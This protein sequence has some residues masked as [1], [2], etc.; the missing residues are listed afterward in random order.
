M[1]D[2]QAVQLMVDMFQQYMDHTMLFHCLE[3]HFQID[4]VH[5][6]IDQVKLGMYQESRLHM[7][8]LHSHFGLSQ[9][10]M[11]YMSQFLFHC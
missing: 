10:H 1:Q 4:R 8:L 2:M 3:L 6:P 7:M 9:V 5:I 11:G